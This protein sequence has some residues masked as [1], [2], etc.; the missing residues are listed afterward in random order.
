M[1]S[2]LAFLNISFEFI[3]MTFNIITYSNYMDSW[4]CFSFS[5]SSFIIK[6]LMIHTS[7][8]KGLGWKYP[9]ILE[10]LTTASGFSENRFFWRWTWMNVNNNNNNFLI[11]IINIHWF[12]SQDKGRTL[13][14]QTPVLWWW[15]WSNLFRVQVWALYSDCVLLRPHAPLSHTNNIQR[16]IFWGGL[17]A[18]IG[19]ILLIRGSQKNSFPFPG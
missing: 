11:N 8:N 18:G 15:D 6:R 9:S 2:F 3:S 13:F 16:N 14:S 10:R 7:S 19:R 12:I 1:F 5:F 17:A 4:M